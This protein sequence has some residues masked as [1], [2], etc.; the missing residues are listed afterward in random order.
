MF[1]TNPVEV[2]FDDYGVP[3]IY[4]ESES[5]AMKV[6]AISMRWKGSGK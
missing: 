6:L 5:D 4:A 1:L 2:Y 3:H